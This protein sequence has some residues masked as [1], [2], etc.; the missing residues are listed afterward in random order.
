MDSQLQRYDE[1]IAAFREAIRRAP[2]FLPAHHNLAA[3]Y[4]EAGRDQEARAEAAEALRLNPE[5]SVDRL[6]E[7]LPF[8]NPA[9]LD[10]LTSALHKAGLK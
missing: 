7:R 2:D 3:T 10:R 9:D 5:F 8:K 6:R 1:A 4:A